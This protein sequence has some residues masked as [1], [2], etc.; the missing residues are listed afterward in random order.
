MPKK[1]KEDLGNQKAIDQKKDNQLDSS[2]SHSDSEIR[3]EYSPDM[4]SA[5]TRLGPYEILSTI[6]AGGMGEVYR[7]RD[8]RIGREVAIKV[9][10][11]HFSED[12]E[13]LRRFEHEARAA[14]ALNHPNILT[15]FDIGTENNVPYLV[16]ELLQGE[17]LRRR[18]SD[19][20][21]SVRKTV[22]FALQIAHGLSA[23]HEKSIVHRD[24][25]PENLFITKDG[26]V[27]ILDFG[28]AKLIHPEVSG[29][30]MTQAPTATHQTEPGAVM[31]TI[32]YMS[33]EQVRGLKVDHRSD[34]FAFGSIL[35]EMLFGKRPFQGETHVEVMHAILKSEPPDLLQSNSNMSP[36]LERIVRRCLEKEPDH[37]FQ[38]TSDLAFALE[39]LSTSS[40]STTSLRA[41]RVTVP[42]I[43]YLLAVAIFTAAAIG[44]FYAGEKW[45]TTQAGKA[46]ASAPPS[47]SFSWE[48]MTFRRGYVD[49]AAFSPDGQTL[50]YSAD[51]GVNSR[52]VYFSRLGSPEARSLGLKSATVLSV[53]ANGD[54]AVLLNRKTLAQMPFAGGVPRELLENV[55]DADWSPDGKGL[56]VIH[57]NKLEFPI[58]KVL[59]QPKNRLVNVSFSPKGDLIAFLEMRQP[60]IGSINIIG[61]QGKPKKLYEAD[62]T[63]GA[64]GAMGL[65]FS[66][67]GDEIWFGTRPK[68]GTGQILCAVTLSGKFREVLPLNGNFR[69]FGISKDGRILLNRGETKAGIVYF[70]PSEGKERDLSW[71]SGSELSDISDDGKVL[72]FT[73]NGDR[74]GDSDR[75][76]YVRNVDSTDA[77]RLGDGWP[78]DLSPDGK[79]ATAILKGTVILLPTGAGQ[80][81]TLV[82]GWDESSASFFPD[83][84]R[85]LFW[86]SKAGKER[87]YVQ[88]LAGGEAMPVTP[89]RVN[90]YIDPFE[91]SGA[92]SPDGKHFIASDNE[93]GYKVYPMDGGESTQING[94]EEGEEPLSW[95]LDGKAIFVESGSGESLVFRIDLK[96][97][98]R[99]LWKELRPPDPIGVHYVGPKFTPDGKTYA[100]AYWRTLSD[101]YAIEGLK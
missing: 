53:S 25:K 8:P 97:G 18:L 76:I 52:E 65:A 72:L 92:I 7:A 86:A 12:P 22:D 47:P 33:P 57:K 29:S 98:Q 54:L 78:I 1:E 48:R 71:L 66:A 67:T 27:K 4:P 89:E 26:R 95:S 14:G 81:R 34:I 24:L 69:L 96:T 32:V 15:I 101:L 85:I 3:V 64:S 17:T 80:S 58:G 2:H 73:E 84:K 56:A 41:E 60:G 44:F 90:V 38:S 31:G 51:W 16:S 70:S 23:A 35:Y 13:R 99:Q 100:Y 55:Q 63:T 6:G 77:V 93:N 79:W 39:S 28:L 94:L 5:G 50:V 82:Q 9:L 21:L 20:P 61:L 30:Q 11:A 75:S 40:A 74:A 87:I 46:L 45:E 59:Y 68:K 37:R 83:G 19:G 62:M 36:G 42:W 43:R 88:D 49:G 10:P 91:A